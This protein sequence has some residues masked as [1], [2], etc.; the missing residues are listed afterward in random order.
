M[1]GANP[2]SRHR[3]SNKKGRFYDAHMIYHKTSLI[4]CFINLCIGLSMYCISDQVKKT[5]LE[6]TKWS[7]FPK[8]KQY[9]TNSY[10]NSF[11]YLKFLSGFFFYVALR[12]LPRRPTPPR[13]TFIPLL[14]LQSKFC[15]HSSIFIGKCATLKQSY[16]W[17]GFVQRWAFRYIFWNL[18]VSYT[19][20]KT[21][22][23]IYKNIR[24]TYMFCRR[25]LHLRTDSLWTYHEPT[26][27]FNVV[28][29]AVIV[30]NSIQ[31]V[32]FLEHTW[33]TFYASINSSG[34]R[35]RKCAQRTWQKCCGYEPV[36]VLYYSESRGQKSRSKMCIY[37]GIDNTD[38][39]CWWNNRIPKR[40]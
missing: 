37:L 8:L 32:A 6:E 23:R 24:Q 38:S 2:R 19:F 20:Q 22:C 27:V 17:K 40:K 3:L 31:N 18:W 28:D 15:K 9:N 36:F 30:E 10:F 1:P 26:R 33:G 35:I 7:L 39:F 11:F 16:T 13:H 12:Q 29:V 4:T 21:Y 34:G 5:S 25:Q 14:L